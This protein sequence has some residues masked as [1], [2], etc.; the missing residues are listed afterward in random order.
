M[1]FRSTRR[2]RERVQ[3][4]SGR[5]AVRKEVA[6]ASA[7]QCLRRLRRAVIRPPVQ[8]IDGGW[9]GPRPS[10]A[11]SRRRTASPSALPCRP[12]TSGGDRGVDGGFVMR[13]SYGEVGGS[14]PGGEVPR[15][16]CVGVA[17]AGA[18]HFIYFIFFRAWMSLLMRCSSLDNS[19]PLDAHPMAVVIWII[20]PSVSFY[21][22]RD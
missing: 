15:W 11:V 9:P 4:G 2:P 19:E 3:S 17:S 8:L 21:I 14:D 12:S 5:I 13:I 10:R 16:A 7:L 1:L 20:P 18:A 22:S 6:A